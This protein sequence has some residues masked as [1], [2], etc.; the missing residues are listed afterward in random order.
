MK[1]NNV[2]KFSTE[3]PETAHDGHTVEIVRPLTSAECDIAEVGP[4]QRVRCLD[5]QQE[6]D[7]FPEELTGPDV[8]AKLR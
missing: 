7:A 5:D 6:F 1:W 4:M 8:P 2:N 3:T